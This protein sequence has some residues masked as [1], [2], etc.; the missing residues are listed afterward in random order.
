MEPLPG[1]ELPAFRRRVTVSFRRNSV[2]TGFNN[3]FSS[4]LFPNGPK[5]YETN[6]IFGQRIGRKIGQGEL[7]GR[8]IHVY[9]F[10]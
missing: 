3:A 1:S 9:I 10:L 7:D 4:F 5:V 2:F 6:S 8:N